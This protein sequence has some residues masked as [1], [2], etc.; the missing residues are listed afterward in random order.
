[1]KTLRQVYLEQFSKNC[2]D[3]IEL[4]KRKNADYSA[5]DDAFG[6]FRQSEQIAG[7]S[8]PKGIL[9]RIGD[10]LSRIKNLMDRPGNQGE[11][12]DEKLEDTIMDLVTYSNILLTWYQLGEPTEGMEFVDTKNDNDY[13]IVSP[14]IEKPTI[15]DALLKWTSKLKG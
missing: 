4:T 8:V 14:G 2:L 12:L 5:G 9:V 3:I 11:V 7:V 6:N 15:K 13:N 10:K 1:M